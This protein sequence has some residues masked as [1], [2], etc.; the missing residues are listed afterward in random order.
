MAYLTSCVTEQMESGVDVQSIEFDTAVRKCAGH[1][2]QW[3]LAAL[4]AVRSVDLEGCLQ[5]VGYAKCF[6]A[7][8]LPYQKTCWKKWYSGAERVN[9]DSEAIEEEP[10]LVSFAD[11]MPELHEELQQQHPDAEQDQFYEDGE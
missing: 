11:H 4:D 10:R 6:G 2:M 5:S 3:L 1:A 7:V 8:G 9:F